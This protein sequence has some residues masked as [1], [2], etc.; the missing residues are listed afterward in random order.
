M[1]E[2]K[3]GTFMPPEVAVQATPGQSVKAVSPSEEEIRAYALALFDDARSELARADSKGSLLLGAAGLI[4]SALTGAVVGGD[5][6][7]NKLDSRWSQAAFALGLAA[8]VAGVL[9]IGAAVIPKVRKL[10][11]SD[12][13]FH[14][15]HLAHIDQAE[16]RRRIANTIP[17]LTQRSI[18]QAWW[19]SQIAFRKY[20]LIRKSMLFFLL[21]FIM[22]GLVPT[23]NQLG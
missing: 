20:A 14:F 19:M 23:L 22:A 2:P 10:P 17:L 9:L 5:W 16:A 4:L 8:V 13:A 7:P 12:Y 15:G 3:Q 11:E 18:D 1:T 21:A 6:T